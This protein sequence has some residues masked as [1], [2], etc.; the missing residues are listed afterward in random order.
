M[1]VCA[2]EGGVFGFGHGMQAVDDD[3]VK[4]HG[5]R[6]PMGDVQCLAQRWR[7]MED[8]DLRLLEMDMVSTRERG[9]RGI[10]GAARGLDV[11]G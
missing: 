3:A 8:R 9:R 2:G 5:W 1:R 10:S 4:G 11:R 6:Q 7:G